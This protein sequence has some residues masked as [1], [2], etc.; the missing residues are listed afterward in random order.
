MISEVVVR[1][2]ENYSTLLCARF[3]DGVGGLSL[4]EYKKGLAGFSSLV[5]KGF[6]GYFL[7]SCAWLFFLLSWFAAVVMVQIKT[8][9]KIEMKYMS[10]N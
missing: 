8:K 3:G 10:L 5:E 1:N 2:Y 7:C 9:Q 6:P 4:E